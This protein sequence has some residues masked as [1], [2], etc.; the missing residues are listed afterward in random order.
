MLD[1]SDC[2]SG[3]LVR[4]LPAPALSAGHRI[5]PSSRLAQHRIERRLGLLD[6]SL[7]VTA[8]LL[9]KQARRGYQQQVPLEL[10]QRHPGL[11]GSRIQATPSRAA[12][13]WTLVL[14]TEMTRS[15]FTSKFST[16]PA[17][18]ASNV[19]IA[20]MIGST[21]N[22]APPSAIPFSNLAWQIREGSKSIGIRKLCCTSHL[23]RP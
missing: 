4:C 2:I 22:S 17:R 12:T 23:S 18:P 7:P 15:R 13:T 8:K 3:V 19:C 20:S 9:A 14:V 1:D 16:L 11:V 21:D 6:I 5:S 10:I